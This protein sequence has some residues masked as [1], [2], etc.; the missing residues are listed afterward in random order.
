M[1]TVNAFANVQICR[2]YKIDN[3][4]RL[5]ITALTILPFLQG[6]CQT[7]PSTTEGQTLANFE[8][9]SQEEFREKALDPNVVIIDVRSE[10]EIAQ[11]Y[12]KGTSVFAD[13]NSSKFQEAIQNLDKSKTYLVY[14]RSGARSGR[15]SS[16]MVKQGF[17]SVFN[18]SG[19]I[20]SWTGE[21]TK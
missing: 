18:L 4:K 11:G 15:A 8:N 14:C 19:G 20:S 5:L 10:G 7:R 6:S 1:V 21:V 2:L 16:I 3:M 17:N 12:I 9:I 13:V